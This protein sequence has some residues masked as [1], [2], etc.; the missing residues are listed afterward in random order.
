V[1]HFSNPRICDYIRMTIG[2]DEQMALCI[3]AIRAILDE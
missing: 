3:A 1:R 2:T